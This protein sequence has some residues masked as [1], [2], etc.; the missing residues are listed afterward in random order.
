[1]AQLPD[2]QC[3][4]MLASTQGLPTLDPEVLDK[5]DHVAP[6]RRTLDIF[7]PIDSAKLRQALPDISPQRA[8]NQQPVA[9]IDNLLAGQPPCHAPLIP[10][11]CL[12][13]QALHQVFYPRCSCLPLVLACPIALGGRGP[14]ATLS[15]LSKLPGGLYENWNNDAESLSFRWNRDLHEGDN[16][17][18][19]KN[20]F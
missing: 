6:D 18:L 10:Q 4:P 14:R 1:M 11:N 5:M 20:R 9:T 15:L 7:K 3:M 17:A 12:L 13:L 2:G 19:I 16:K 8:F